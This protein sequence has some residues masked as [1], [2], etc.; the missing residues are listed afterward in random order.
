MTTLSELKDDLEENIRDELKELL[1][2]PYQE[3]QLREIADG[4]V[5]EKHGELIELLESDWSLAIASEEYLG[6]QGSH[7]VWDIIQASLR[8]ILNDHAFEYFREQ[9]TEYQ[10]LVS[11]LESEHYFLVAV[12]KDP[13]DRTA[14][15]KYE[16]WQGESGDEDEEGSVLIKD[17]FASEFDAWKWLE[18]NPQD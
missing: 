9:N 5:T 17:D 13:K 14:G 1:D 6:E 7:K 16:I 2:N 10:E 3:D 12:R 4:W 8:E 15:Y 18:A 11:E